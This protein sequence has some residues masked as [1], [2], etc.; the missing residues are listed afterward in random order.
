MEQRLG[1]WHSKR[2]GLNRQSGPSVHDDL[3]LR[4]FTAGK[5]NQLWLTDITEQW[6]DEGKLYLCAIKDG[7]SNRI[8]GYSIDSRLTAELAVAALRSTVALSEPTG[9][10]L[11]LHRGSQVRSRK[12][13]EQLRVFGITG[14]MGRVGCLRGQRGDGVLLLTAAEETL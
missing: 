1:S 9:T 8:V 10:T 3:V 13:V 7:H 12:F 2:G 14:S 4:D 11:H 5:L 6:T